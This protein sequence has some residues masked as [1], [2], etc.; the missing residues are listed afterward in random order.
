[1]NTSGL[2]IS[3]ALLSVSLAPAQSTACW[4][5]F[6][7]FILPSIWFYTAVPIY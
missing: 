7:S 4:A 6:Q 2:E 1:M 5:G 3:A